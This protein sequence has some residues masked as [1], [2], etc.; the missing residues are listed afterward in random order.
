MYRQ[1]FFDLVLISFCSVGL[2]V[3]T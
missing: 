3:A 2:C 1:K